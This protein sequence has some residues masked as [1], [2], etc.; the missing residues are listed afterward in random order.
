[1]VARLSVKMLSFPDRAFGVDVY[2]RTVKKRQRVLKSRP[3]D[4]VGFGYRQ[5]ESTTIFTSAFSMCPTHRARTSAISFTPST[6]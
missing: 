3:S 1:M 2:D 5:L 6:R 4:L